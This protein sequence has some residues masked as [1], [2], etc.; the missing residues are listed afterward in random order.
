MA[1]EPENVWHQFDAHAAAMVKEPCPPNMEIIPRASCTLITC[2]HC[3]EPTILISCIEPDG[4]DVTAALPI[5]TA[6]AFAQQILAL[7]SEATGSV[8]KPN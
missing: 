4:H 8:P 2:G 6:V 7:A 1:D 5:E 3:Q